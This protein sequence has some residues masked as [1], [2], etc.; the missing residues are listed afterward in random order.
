MV[1]VQDTPITEEEW[2]SADPEK[3]QLRDSKGRRW[4]IHSKP[5]HTNIG[6]GLMVQCPGHNKELLRMTDMYGGRSIID[7][8]HGI[9]LE[10]HGEGAAIVSIKQE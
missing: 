3:H 6:W 10:L 4:E 5:I 8:E 2:Q 7:G 1:E 9:I